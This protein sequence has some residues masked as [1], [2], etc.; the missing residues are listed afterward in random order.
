MTATLTS[1]Q[2]AVE[3]FLSAPEAVRL[4]A[5]SELIAALKPAAAS[6]DPTETAQALRRAVLPTLD[7]TSA[8]TLCRIFRSLKPRLG[9][10]Q[11]PTRIAVLGNVTMHQFVHFLEL[12]L[13]AGGADAEIYEAEY[14]LMR[15]DILDPQSGLY[16]FRPKL[17]FL[18]ATHRDLGHVPHLQDTTPVVEQRL[19]NEVADW[20]NLWE[21]V[22]QRL[23]CQVLQNNFA[24]P[25]YRI[26]GHF[27]NRFPAA[28]SNYIRKVNSALVDA[29]PP[30]VT[31]H[32]IDHLSAAAG[33]WSW[34]DE[35]FFHQAKLPCAPESLVDYAHSV[36]SIIAA[37]LGLAKKCLVL[38]LDNTLWGGVIGDDGI[39]GIRLGQ[40]DPEA[41]AFQAFQHYARGL[42]QRG[43]ILAVC[44]K[45]EDRIARDAFDK[46]T[47][48]V[49]RHG[50]I[51]CFV[52][53]WDDKATNLRRIASQL[54]IGLN[55][56]V[57]V[58]DNP[59]ERS[60]VRQL[61]PEV[62]V[63][64]LPVDPAGYIQAIEQHRYFE[65]VSLGE[66]DLKRTDFYLANAAREQAE[67]TSGSIED[68]LKSLTMVARMGPVTSATLER[69]AQLIARSNQFNLT[70]RRYSA[71]EVM[72]MVESGDWL[73]RT[74]SLAD[75]FGD[76]GL[77]CVM[78][79]KVEPP[80]LRIDTWLMSCR[81]LKRG[82]EDL[83]LNELV[84]EARARGLSR[85]LGDYLPTA[86]NALV[87][88]HYARLGF[89]QTSADAD[90]ATH[91]KLEIVPEWPRRVHFIE[92]SADDGR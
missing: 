57:F 34:G 66:E 25:P 75:R 22:H 65:T 30:F 81:V 72:A 91:W 1:I 52:A 55:S 61:V 87:K 4:R 54:N 83:L 43:I 64:E 37:H 23:G 82:V 19:R 47:E 49:L 41:E 15:Q 13:F 63:P 68:F 70:T 89:E 88:E 85:L 39:D 18:A 6:G 78:L 84:N 80:A 79:A 29:A 69:T 31:F 67:A 86:K 48:M 11:K 42:R 46:H 7:Y 17:V 32:D 74:V 26:V 28:L 59:A 51:S 35:R 71:A 14:G 10:A 73:T 8:Q 27:E 5:F 60:I 44:S 38:D 21:T 2:T 90:G 76:N 12:F 92:R 45:N 58:D 62:A 16:E 3:R 40:G 33:R 77:I 50:D 20:T 9:S 24:P 56:L 36:A 53:N